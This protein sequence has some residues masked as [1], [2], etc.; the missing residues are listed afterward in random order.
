MTEKDLI[1]ELESAEAN[2]SDDIQALAYVQDD[3]E[4]TKK[5]IE[6]LLKIP[7]IYSQIQILLKA[8]LYNKQNMQNA[9]NKYYNEIKK[10]EKDH[11]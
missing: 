3:L 10:E 9:I 4:T 6:M 7:E 2:L 5:D 1:F 8:M 11:E